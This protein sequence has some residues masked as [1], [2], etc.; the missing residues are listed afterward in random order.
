MKVPGIV[1]RGRKRSQEGKKTAVESNCLSFSNQISVS[2]FPIPSTSGGQ[3]LF[4]KGMERECV[5]VS[6]VGFLTLLEWWA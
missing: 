4:N 5:V 1:Y 6:E 3:V 2:H